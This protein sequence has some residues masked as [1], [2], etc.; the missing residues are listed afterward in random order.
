MLG[1]IIVLLL[2][3]LDHGGCVLVLYYCTATRAAGSWWWCAY[4]VLL[5]CCTSGWIMV[6][7]CWCGTVALLHER[8]DHGCGVLVWGGSVGSCLC[9]TV[10]TRPGLARGCRILTRST[11]FAGAT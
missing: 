4:V 1:C 10:A 7:A 8:L 2:V 3:L 11:R 9:S 5:R 6:V